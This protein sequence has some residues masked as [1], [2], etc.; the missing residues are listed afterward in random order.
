MKARIDEKRKKGVERKGAGG[1][2]TLWL[3]KLLNQNGK[4]KAKKKGLVHPSKRWF[5]AHQKLRSR[6]T[7]TEKKD[8]I[9][10]WERGMGVNYFTRGYP[11]EN[12]RQR[13]IERSRSEEGDRES[14]SRRLWCLGRE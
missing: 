11:T 13:R 12:S 5:I 6:G 9:A 1:S 3:G 14:L 10:V 7:Q 4:K 2:L 8:T